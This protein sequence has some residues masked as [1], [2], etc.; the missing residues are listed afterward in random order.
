MK[1]KYRRASWTR[2]RLPRAPAWAPEWPSVFAFRRFPRHADIV[3]KADVKLCQGPPFTSPRHPGEQQPCKPSMR[4]PWAGLRRRGF[5]RAPAAKDKR[6]GW[7]LNAIVDNF[8]NFARHRKLPS[9]K[10]GQPW[11]AV[12]E[13]TGVVVANPDDLTPHIDTDISISQYDY[14]TRVS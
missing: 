14:D 6:H 7:W 8:M 11:S 5:T 13:L 9:D 1:Q 10:T 4:N 2:L 12:A 3:E